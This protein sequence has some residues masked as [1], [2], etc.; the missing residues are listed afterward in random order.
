MQRETFGFGTRLRFKDT[1]ANTVGNRTTE[2][3]L[4]F[5]LM[6]NPTDALK[7]GLVDQRVPEDKVLST[8]SETM[9]KWFALPGQ[10]DR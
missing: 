3:S 6:Y 4:Q 2:L 1:M 10:A 5:G 7:I 9:M 8:A